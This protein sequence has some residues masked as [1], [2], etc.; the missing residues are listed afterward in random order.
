MQGWLV[1]M[2]YKGCG[3]K[4]QW[5][6][7]KVISYRIREGAGKIHTNVSQCNSYRVENPD[8]EFDNFIATSDTKY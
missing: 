2:I 7:F 4:W 3:M 6:I 1:V 5:P 8:Y